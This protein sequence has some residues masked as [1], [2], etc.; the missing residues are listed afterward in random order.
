MSS[1]FVSGKGV[2]IY[3]E[4]GIYRIGNNAGNERKGGR[5]WYIATVIF[6]KT[7]TQVQHDDFD[8]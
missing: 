1:C 4:E 7:E 6:L 3:A 2:P 5:Q 8:E